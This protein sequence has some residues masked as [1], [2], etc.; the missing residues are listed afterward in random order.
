MKLEIKLNLD[1]LLKEKKKSKYW[2]SKETSI[3]QG[4]INKMCRNETTA[5]KF[6]VLLRILLALECEPNDIFRI[7]GNTNKDQ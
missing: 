1:K 5:I 7:E 3:S 2:L 4:N 6:D